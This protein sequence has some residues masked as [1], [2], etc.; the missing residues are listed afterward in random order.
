MKISR[1]MV[2][3]ST[4]LIVAA[5]GGAGTAGAQEPPPRR[6]TLVVTPTSGRA[7][8]DVVASGA[9]C[10]S[11]DG[12]PVFVGVVLFVDDGDLTDD[13]IVDGAETFSP[14]SPGGMSVD[15]E[16]NWTLDIGPLPDGLD[17]AADYAVTGWCTTD[18]PD[19]VEGNIVAFFDDVP[20][21]VL[22]AAVTEP[23]IPASSTTPPPAVVPAAEPATPVAATPTFT[24]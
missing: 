10:I 21:D 24:G 13:D 5:V 16:G 17:P 6:P 2:A 19:P 9:H 14:G 15:A 23:T 8:T 12:H 4:G 3:A 20:F 11:P 1:L 18:S 7:G 22:G